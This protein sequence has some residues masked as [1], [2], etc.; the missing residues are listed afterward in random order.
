MQFITEMI[1]VLVKEFGWKPNNETYIDHRG[2]TKRSHDLELE[3]LTWN[4]VNRYNMWQHDIN[5]A[6]LASLN[7]L[8]KLFTEY[9]IKMPVY[10]WYSLWECYRNGKNVSVERRICD[11]LVRYPDVFYL[12]DTEYGT[13]AEVTKI[14]MDYELPTDCDFMGTAEL[15]VLLF[16][17]EEEK[18][19]WRRW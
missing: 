16:G 17:S 2:I 12:E 8:C 4:R 7:N 11:I 13:F 3:V 9:N 14:I 15:R 5:P 19:D 6:N 10:S 1:T 18:K